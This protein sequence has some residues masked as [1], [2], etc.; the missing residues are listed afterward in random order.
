MNRQLVAVE[1]GLSN[2]SRR[3]KNVSQIK[4]EKEN[5]VGLV[6]KPK[7]RKY[8]KQNSIETKVKKVEAFLL[9]N[10]NVSPIIINKVN[11]KSSQ[12]NKRMVQ[13]QV[14]FIK[15]FGNV[16]NKVNN[17]KFVLA[18]TSLFSIKGFDYLILAKK[19][20]LQQS[21]FASCKT[22]KDY[23]EQLLSIYNFHARKT[24][25]KVA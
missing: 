3:V 7:K 14:T 12:S 25:L 24:K 16:F 4:E 21:S 17:T 19:L 1:S 2:K 11:K 9:K 18:L 6:E 10:P 8:V 5:V 22:V 23:K 13:S 20:Y 15:T